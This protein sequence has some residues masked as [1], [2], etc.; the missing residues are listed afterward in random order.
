MTSLHLSGKLL[1]VNQAFTGE[2]HAYNYDDRHML[3]DEIRKAKARLLRMHFESRIGHIGGNLSCLDLLMYLH[4][5]VLGKTDLFVLSKGH[6]AGA[7]Y[8]TLWSIGKLTD[9]DLTTFH[10]DGTRLS[11]HPSANWIPEI[12]FGTGS[13]GHGLS[14][15][16]GVALGKQLKNEPGRVFCLISDGELNEGSTWESLMFSM[17]RKLDN[18]TIIVDANGL[19]GFGATRE[20]SDL[21][22]PEQV[23][24]ALGIATTVINGHNLEE[25]ESALSV[26]TAGP[27]AI[28][29]NTTKGFG[30]S[31]M[32]NKMEW[33]YLSMTQA[34]YE[35]A[36]EEIVRA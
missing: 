12:R 29:A 26:T 20:V 31:F 7:L 18:L 17:H 34:Q 2:G 30:V 33:H 36:L 13:L 22:P 8:V 32:E 9:T 27:H 15:A 10:K 23:I 24:S 35:T 1:W 16:A 5:K 3:S 11:G 4:H 19:Q 21:G 14:L 6:A 25:I 28:V